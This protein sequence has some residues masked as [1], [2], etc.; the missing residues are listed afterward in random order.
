MPKS[1]IDRQEASPDAG[2]HDGRDGQQGVSPLLGIELTTTENTGENPTIGEDSNRVDP[3][4]PLLGTI[5]RDQP[6]ATLR[7]AAQ[8]AA[9]RVAE[10]SLTWI[11]LAA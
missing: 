3:L 5:C 10:C 4:A 2:G 7:F 6:A 11:Y 9:G 8:S 1:S